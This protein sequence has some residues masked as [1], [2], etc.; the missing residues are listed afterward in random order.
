MKD[1][2]MKDLAVIALV[3]WLLFMNGFT[4]IKERMNS[5]TPGAVASTIIQ[6]AN[7]AATQAAAS[8][9]GGAAVVRSTS[10]PRQPIRVRPAPSNGGSAPQVV[11][12][13]QGNPVLP[14][15]TPEPTTT[16][17]PSDH[18]SML[19]AE[20]VDAAAIREATAQAWVEQP[21]ST[22]EPNGIPYVPESPATLE[23]VYEDA[24]PSATVP[25]AD[26]FVDGD[27]VEGFNC[28]EYITY[29]AG[30]PCYGD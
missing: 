19:T 3:F 9:T 14:T 5:H 7:A 15:A 1:F 26:T 4:W 23:P 2:S 18:D 17:E 8:G 10:T 16:P 12:R 22:P 25:P 24:L 11:I 6:G 30:H 28:S 20:A 27:G 29:F 21:A 13:P